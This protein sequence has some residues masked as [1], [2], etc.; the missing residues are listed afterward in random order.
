MRALRVVLSVCLLAMMMASCSP[1]NNASGP[2]VV[3]VIDTGIAENSVTELRDYTIENQTEPVSGEH[4]TMMASVLL[5]VNDEGAEALPPDR[6]VLVSYDIGE[7]AT[8]TGIAEAIEAAVDRRVDVI[9]ISMGVRQDS[10]RLREAVR[11]AEEAGIPIIAAAG[12]VRFLASDFPA[13]CS[14]VVSVSAVD[15][16]GEWWSDAARREVDAV[17]DGVDVSVLA[18]NGEVR[19]ES[20]TSISTAAVTHQLVSALIAGEVDSVHDFRF[21]Q[22]PDGND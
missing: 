20:G 17:A 21:P 9:S 12:N 5:G 18:P 11:I 22:P 4:G 1:H 16:A 6:V 8:A 14:S 15:S 2:I 19:L 3:A 7:N 10:P 13:R